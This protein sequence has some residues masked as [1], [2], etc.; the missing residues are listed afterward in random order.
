M[1]SFCGRRFTAMASTRPCVAWQQIRVVLSSMAASTVSCWDR[2]PWP[3]VASSISLLN[4]HLWDPKKIWNTWM[5]SFYRCVSFL[6][7]FYFAK[8]WKIFL[9]TMQLWLIP[10]LQ[11]S[12]HRL[13][14]KLDILLWKL[15]VIRFTV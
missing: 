3:H 10:N 15:S 2:L 9:S 13:L 8:A 14:S 4:S 1:F 7:L 6:C 11:M 5:K 12:L